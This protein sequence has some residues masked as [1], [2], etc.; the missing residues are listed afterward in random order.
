L[1]VAFGIFIIPV[2]FVV[3]KELDEKLHDKLAKEEE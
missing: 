1:G 3:F 2:L